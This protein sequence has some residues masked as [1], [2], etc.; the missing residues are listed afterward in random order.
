M[1]DQEKKHAIDDWRVR[2]AFPEELLNPSK[3]NPTEQKLI[4]DVEVAPEEEEINLDEIGTEGSEEEEDS[5]EDDDKYP[6]PLEDAQSAS[7]K[8]I[9]EDY[10][11]GKCEE[12]QELKD[13]SEESSDEGLPK[14][15]PP[16]EDIPDEIQF[17]GTGGIFTMGHDPLPATLDGRYE[18]VTT[19]E[20]ENKPIK[21]QSPAALRKKYLIRH[22]RIFPHLTEV[23]VRKPNT[24]EE[25]LQCILEKMESIEMRLTQQK[26]R[27][28]EQRKQFLKSMEGNPL[29]GG[30]GRG[31]M[32]GGGGMPGMPNQACVIQ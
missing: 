26:E 30:Q 7:L 16:L 12:T 29:L 2:G 4:E 5:G 6:P 25:Y 1:T 28:E 20:E 3:E 8:E 21:D 31:M 14:H 18:Q 11:A 10:N 15:F 24:I 9:N 27:E 17:R 32:P 19:V 22:K 23:K 13:I